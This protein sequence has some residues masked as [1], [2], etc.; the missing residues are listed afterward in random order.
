MET[1]KSKYKKGK[2]PNSLKNLKPIEKG[3]ARNPNGRPS[4]RLCLT[5]I[6][7]EKLEQVCPYDS[8]GRTWKEYLVE[9]WLASS[10]ENVTYFR[11]LIDRLE[12]KVVQTIGGEGVVTLRV[13]YDDS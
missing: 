7:R 13:I 12:G 6:A 3:E 5:H 9:R 8:E 10:L 1:E 4:N 11:E 2:N